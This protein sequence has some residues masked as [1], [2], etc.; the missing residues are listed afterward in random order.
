MCRAWVD[1]WG[2]VVSDTQSIAVGHDVEA[3]K[4]DTDTAEDGWDEAIRN[5]VT[6][7][8]NPEWTNCG[9]LR[10]LRNSRSYRFV[11]ESS[12]MGCP[13]KFSTNHYIF[14]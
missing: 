8:E 11:P 6:E 4:D 14:W 1:D 7:H 13:W 9:N 2:Y 12:S 3:V 10:W 5:D